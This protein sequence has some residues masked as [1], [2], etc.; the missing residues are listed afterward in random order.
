MIM[1]KEKEK[2]SAAVKLWT[3]LCHVKWYHCRRKP[4]SL[5]GSPCSY[6]YR[7]TRRYRGCRFALNICKIYTFLANMCRR[8]PSS[9]KEP[10][11]WCLQASAMGNSSH[12]CKYFNLDELIVDN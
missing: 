5:R 2:S 10:Q 1:T 6:V 12:L 3:P 8:Y 7:S 9:L 4:S 11:W